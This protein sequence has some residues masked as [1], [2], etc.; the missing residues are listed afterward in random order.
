[1]TGRRVGMVTAGPA[2]AGAAL[3]LTVWRFGDAQ[4][5]STWPRT[6]AWIGL[7]ALLGS[8]AALALPTRVER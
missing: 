1:M 2:I 4:S 7:A 6:L 8:G 3:A 5:A